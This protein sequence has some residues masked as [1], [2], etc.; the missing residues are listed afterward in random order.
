V[1]QRYADADVRER[2]YQRHMASFGYLDAGTQ[3]LANTA[4]VTTAPLERA[5]ISG[6]QLRAKADAP[7]DE[8]GPAAAEPL[9]QL[10]IG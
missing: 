4:T 3:S 9:S 7:D 1:W 5:R 8:R 2:Q 10:W 6:P